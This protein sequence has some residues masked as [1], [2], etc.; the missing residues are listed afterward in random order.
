MQRYLALQKI[1]ELGSFSKAAEALGYTQSATSQMIASLE[2]ELSIKLLN[3]SHFGANLTLEGRELYPFL[4]QII[5]AY[6]LSQEKARE[7]RGLE[8]GI[9]R[10]GLP[11]SISAHWMPQ[12]LKEFQKQ[13]PHVEFVIYTGDYSSIYEWIKNGTVDFG[14]VAPE[15]SPGIESTVLTHGIMLALLPP[16]H[17]LSEH[18]IMPLE[19]LAKEPFILLEE[20]QYSEVLEAFKR[21]GLTPN[22]KY[23]IH[24]NDTII[25][26]VEA[27]LGI[28]ILSELALH[29]T[30]YNIEYYPTDPPLF[31]K[32]AIGYKSRS[33]LPVATQEFI[34][35]M[36]SQ[37]RNLP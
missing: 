27:G 26:M 31:R 35:F 24:D 11:G 30:Y 9:V 2:N 15:A 22:I 5:N 29:R 16:N 4:E 28:S 23:T 10:V 36:Q 14:F 12:L 3:R 33:H 17:P 21:E 1:V 19:L 32:I 37:V 8:T 34:K 18:M 6:R 7:I 13:Y 20:G 25:T